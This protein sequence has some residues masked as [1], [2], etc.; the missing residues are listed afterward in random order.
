M[1]DFL[2]VWRS[3]TALETPEAIAVAR[4]FTL[5]CVREFL[6]RRGVA[7]AR[8]RSIE[9]GALLRYLVSPERV[10]YYGE[11]PQF[12]A[13]GMVLCF[14]AFSGERFGRYERVMLSRPN[15]GPIGLVVRIPLETQDDV[16]FSLGPIYAGLL[17]FSTDP[18][19]ERS[20]IQ[21]ALAEAWGE[22][23]A[24]FSKEECGEHA[25][26]GWRVR[27][28]EWD[29]SE[30][31]LV[32]RIAHLLTSGTAVLDQLQP[33]QSVPGGVATARSLH[34]RLLRRGYR[35]SPQQVATF[36]A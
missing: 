31:D 1:H 11:T 25:I 7:E 6:R 3:G 33:D 24:W 26:L 4:R 29:G 21:T 23:P 28:A 12:E 30:S 35:F 2:T 17:W 36:Y 10:R 5:D 15:R 22:E 20:G 18:G 14:K 13:D 19:A 16:H 9:Q 27:P 8:W 34:E 32:G